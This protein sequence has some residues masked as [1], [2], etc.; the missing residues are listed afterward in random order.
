MPHRDWKLR[1]QDILESIEGV[2][3]Y[4]SGMSVDDFLRDQRTID[5]VLRKLTIIGE[6]AGHVPDVICKK[7]PFLIGEE[8]A[9]GQGL[10]GAIKTNCQRFLENAKELPGVQ[11]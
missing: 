9:F 7:N 3:N 6:A 11:L 4:V 5:A 2:Q 8:H 1:I 10:L